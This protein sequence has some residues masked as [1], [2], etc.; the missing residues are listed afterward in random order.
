M[1]ERDR[2]RE[3]ERERERERQRETERQRQ[4]ETERERSD[5]HTNTAF[6]TKQKKQ[7]KTHRTNFGILVHAHMQIWAF[8]IGAHAAQEMGASWH[9]VLV[10]LENQEER[11]KKKLMKTERNWMKQRG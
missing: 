3:T 6:E 4:R 10:D 7:N 11:Q 1:R 2:Q 5:K 8:F 9:F